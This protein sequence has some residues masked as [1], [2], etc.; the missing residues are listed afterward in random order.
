MGGGR[1]QNVIPNVSMKM[2]NWTLTG[3]LGAD[4]GYYN[5]NYAYQVDLE[6][7]YSISKKREAYL[8]ASLASRSAGRKTSSL[9]DVYIDENLWSL[10]VGVHVPLAN[11]KSRLA[12]RGGFGS[13]WSFQFHNYPSDWYY[14]YGTFNNQSS[15]TPY[16]EISYQLYAF[17]FGKKQKLLRNLVM[18]KMRIDDKAIKR[19]LSK[20]FNPYW[21]IG[22]GQDRAY[23]FIPEGGLRVGPVK[24]GASFIPLYEGHSLGGKVFVDVAQLN[25]RNRKYNRILTAGVIGSEVSDGNDYSNLI[26]LSTG[27]SLEKKKGRFALDIS[28]GV[29]KT[30]TSWGYIVHDY[31]TGAVEDTRESSKGWLPTVGLSA[32]F[33]VFK[34]QQ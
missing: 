30:Y 10:M 13:L 24:L 31:G 8:A 1:L 17:Q 3:M 23:G 9:G 18:G 19:G 22:V 20:W 21:S 34:F 26:G 32:K 4:N 6:L 2:G 27:L 28:A 33:Y 11:N 12:L 15:N 5:R 7:P 16:G 14:G 29:G 25:S